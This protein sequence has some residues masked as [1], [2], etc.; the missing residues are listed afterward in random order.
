M[1]LG[2]T[3]SA[4]VRHE[5]LV[6]GRGPHPRNPI[7]RQALLVDVRFVLGRVVLLSGVD[8]LFRVELLLVVLLRCR[9]CPCRDPSFE[10]RVRRAGIRRV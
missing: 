1:W 6:L 10:K 7:D 8:R 2:R 3:V 9:R 4:E 5:V